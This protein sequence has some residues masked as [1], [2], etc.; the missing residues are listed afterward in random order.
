MTL[1]S[2]YVGSLADGPDPLDWGGDPNIANAPKR[3]LTPRFPPV[4]A[5]SPDPRSTVVEQ[6]K[7]GEYHGRQVDWGAWAAL[8]TKADIVALVEQ[9][10]GADP[11]LGYPEHL[12]QPMDE[13]RSAVTA[14]AD[15]TRYA[16]IADE[17]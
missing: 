15:N 5:G 12:R 16:L 7:T 17:L 4:R 2:V 3:R 9:L 14:L 10:Y 1:T 6:I 11:Y 13:F 8:V